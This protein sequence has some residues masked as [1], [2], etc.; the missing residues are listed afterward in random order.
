MGVRSQR[1]LKTLCQVLGCLASEKPAAAA[2][3]VAQRIK[4]IEVGLTD[5]NWKRGQYLEL[6]GD[7]APLV[8]K[9]S[10]TSWPRKKS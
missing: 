5:G 9:T 8:D 4:A 1:E 3:L 6:I 10:S 2:D 7:G